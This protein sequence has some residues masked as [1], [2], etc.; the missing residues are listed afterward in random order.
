[1]VITVVGDNG[2][3]GGDGLALRVVIPRQDLYP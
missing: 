2:R 1:M 3:S